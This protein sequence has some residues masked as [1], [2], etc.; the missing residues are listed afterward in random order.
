MKI[1][2]TVLALLFAT[3]LNAQAPDFEVTVE[4]WLDGHDLQSLTE[5][6]QL[7]RNENVAAQILL[8]RIA[9]RPNTFSH[10]T[11]D[12]S[13]KEK[14]S[15]MRKPGG[16]SGKSWMSEAAK[17]SPLALAFIQSSSKDDK[18]EALAQL[19]EKGETQSAIM[20]GY[21]L[22]Q[23]G[24]AD[25]VIEVLAEQIGQ[26]P[27][28]AFALVEAAKAMS[29][30][31]YGR[32]VGSA[33]MYGSSLSSQPS[34]RLRL[35]WAPPSLLSLIEDPKAREVAIEF[36][37]DVT[38]WTPIKN[39]CSNEC[40]ASVKSCTALGASF[41]LF[42]GPFPLRSP[43]ESFVSNEKY[44]NSARISGDLARSY[45]DLRRYDPTKLNQIDAC[46]IPAM[47]KYQRVH[48]FGNKA[49]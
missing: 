1:L 15:L 44:W 13:R 29:R 21:T 4:N 20:V 23:Q 45:G 6:G 30:S 47:I 35:E 38:T 27:L 9:Q 39:F 42:N 19:F 49:Y 32:Y 16:L 14:I 31:K 10:I 36:A 33:S 2:T 8:A 46:F 24:E 17:T 12:L 22:V 26:L 43:S 18:S 28:E 25:L 7:A 3:S 48:G 37:L 34:S 5:L 41:L 40:T 11:K